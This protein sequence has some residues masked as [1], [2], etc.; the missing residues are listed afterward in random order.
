MVNL[1][2][3]F[4]VPGSVGF[5][6]L[7]LATGVA[8]LYASARLQ[9]WG[10]AWLTVL[11]VVYAFLST[12]LGTDLVVA[13]LAG[14]SIESAADV[15]G[16]HSI[17]VL[18]TGGEV[19]R[20]GGLEVAE[21]GRFTSFN[22]LEAARLQRLIGPGATVIASGGI[23]NRGARQRPEA[24]VLADGLVRLGVPRS[25]VI[26]EAGSRTTREQ[27]VLVAALLKRRRVSRFLLVT[28]SDHMGRAAAAFRAEGV[29]PV[30]APSVPRLATAPGLLHRLRPSL[31][32]LRQSDWACYE[33]L[34]RLYYWA[35]GW[36]GAK[37]IGVG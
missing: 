5:L 25:Q 16:L 28:T 4:L 14:E 24:E 13:P 3:L 11:L 20:A 12:P 23:V 33:Y 18:S 9:R 8:L 15:A 17:V 22:A 26:I 7:G 37:T 6:V 1:V 36:W 21:M 35:Q 29:D 10:R 27:A 31:N 34:A 30:A 19:Y 2:K 32:A